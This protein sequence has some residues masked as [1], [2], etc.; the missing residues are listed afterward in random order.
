MKPT[1]AK[2]A[3]RA[4]IPDEADQGCRFRE[5]NAEEETR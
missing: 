2:E 4:Y 1:T 5:G 3:P